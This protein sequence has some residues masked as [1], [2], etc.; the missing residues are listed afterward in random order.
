MNSMVSPCL[1]VKTKPTLF[2]CVSQ[3]K[4]TF[5]DSSMMCHRKSDA[6]VPK[7]DLILGT[8]ATSFFRIQ[9]FMWKRLLI[10]WERAA[11]FGLAS[12]KLLHWRNCGW[13]SMEWQGFG[14]NNKEGGS[15]AHWPEAA[16]MCAVFYNPYTPWLHVWYIYLHLGDF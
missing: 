4:S 9:K 12:W 7:K 1:W 6:E 8:V 13:L 14:A 5:R 11:S 10:S 15:M 2:L 3:M 16:F